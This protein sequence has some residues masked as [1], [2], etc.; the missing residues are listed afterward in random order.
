MAGKMA[1]FGFVYVGMALNLSLGMPDS[2]IPTLRAA[3]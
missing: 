2:Q 1:L 3:A